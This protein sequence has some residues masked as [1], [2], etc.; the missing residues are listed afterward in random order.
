MKDLIGVFVVFLV[1]CSVIFLFRSEV[2]T[3]TLADNRS[4]SEENLWEK[5][6]EW[7]KDSSLKEYVRDDL[8]CKYASIRLQDIKSSFNHSDFN[9]DISKQIFNEHNYAELGENLAKDYQLEEQVIINWLT[10]PSHYKNLIHDYTNSCIKC[11][12]N[13]C[14]QLFAK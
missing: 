9:D 11:E 3:T 4:I 7:R 13:Y 10:S 5:V 8:L 14:V 1:I 6:N 12:N 2:N